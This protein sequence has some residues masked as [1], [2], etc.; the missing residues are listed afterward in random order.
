MPNS[1]YAT[2][3][4]LN[5]AGVSF[6]IFNEFV[7]VVI[8]CFL[9]HDQCCGSCNRCAN[10]CIILIGVLAFALVRE[11]SQLYGYHAEGVAVGLSVSSF[12]HAGNTAAIGLVHGHKFGALQLFF[13]KLDEAASRGI[14]AATGSLRNDYRN[15]AVGRISS[16]FAV[17][18]AAS[19]HNCH[20][21]H[22]HEYN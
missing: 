6:G 12:Y 22:G 17:A 14:G 3:T 18:A 13:H 8:G 4:H 2:V 7:H 20:S 5:L 15:I 10:S 19:Q 21:Q 1:A 11:H 16:L 9:G